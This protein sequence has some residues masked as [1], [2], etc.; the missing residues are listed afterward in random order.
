MNSIKITLPP[1]PH[2]SHSVNKAEWC[3]ILRQKRRSRWTMEVTKVPKKII[4]VI[5]PKRSMTV[6]KE[7]YR[8]KRVAAYCRVSTDSE[9]QLVSYT[10]QKKVYTEMIASRKDWC[11][12]GLFAD[13]GKSGTRADKRPEFNK[14]IND[15]LAGKIDYIITKSVSR[16]ARNTVDCLDYVR[17]LKSKGIG[18]YFEEQQIDTLK[19]DS[20]LYLVIYAGFAQ[21]ESESISKNITWSVRKKFEE[22]TPVF[23]YKRFLGYKKG[24]DGEPEIVPSEAAIVE[25]I[26]NL[27]L[28]GETVDKISKMMQAENYDIPDKTIS[29]SKGMIMNMLSNER[30]CGDAILQKSVT[31]DCIEKKRKKNTGEA[32]M[33][34]VQNNHPAIIDRV[35]FNKVQEELARRKTKTPGSAKSSI[36]STGKYSRYALTDVLIC[37][38]CGTRYRRV[39]WSRNG[40]KRIVWRC[41]SR[42]DYGKKY[43]SDS[44]T[45]M[46]DKLQEAIVRAV[47]KFNEQDNATYK[48]LMRATISEA[49][50]LNGDPEEVDMLSLIHI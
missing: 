10:N 30:Y 7:K 47:N 50:G 33:Y 2:T 43:C 9:E 24:A 5:E 8:Q 39:T 44:P 3:F 27:Y 20:E 19:T 18:V 37:G 17:M 23:M 12:A 14:M 46:E 32:P 38:N 40:T 25:R 22:G 41:I 4:T 21:S 31:V 6:D 36:T 13:E 42:L 34:Y 26:F 49:L 11:F 29:F 28:A 45:I 15:C 35:T 1:S 16:F 48:A